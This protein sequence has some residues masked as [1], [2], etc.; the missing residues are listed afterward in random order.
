MPVWIE[1]TTRI[2]VIS[3]RRIEIG[4]ELT[5]NQNQVALRMKKYLKEDRAARVHRN[6]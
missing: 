2:F 5:I 6:G 1:R 4:T 3:L